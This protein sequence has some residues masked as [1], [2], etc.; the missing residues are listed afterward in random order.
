MPIIITFIIKCEYLVL[1][2]YLMT[3]MLIMSVIK[4]MIIKN[5]YLLLIAL[6]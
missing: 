6:I 2:K 4:T 1:K 5:F 3:I